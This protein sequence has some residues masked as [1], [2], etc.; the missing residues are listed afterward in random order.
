MPDHFACSLWDG[1]LKIY[2]V[3][4]NESNTSFR[5]NNFFIK[6]KAS[7]NITNPWPLTTCTWSPDGNALFVGTCT[8]DV[9]ALD[10]NTGQLMDVGVHPAA[11]N[12]LRYLPEHYN[13]LLTSAYENNVHFWDFKSKNAVQTLSFSKKIF[14][15]SYGG[16][17]IATALADEKIGLTGLKALNI[18]Q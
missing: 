17:V 16:G 7:I 18:R 1:T 2:Q 6:E 3:A 8:G 12:Y 14:K 9:K 4:R 10:I 5:S 15:A 11:I 13:T